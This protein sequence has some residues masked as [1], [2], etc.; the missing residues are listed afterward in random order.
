MK[1]AK[2]ISRVFLAMLLLY[3]GSYLFLSVRGRYEPGGIGLS[4]VRWYDWAPQGFVTGYQRNTAAYMFYWPL[5]TLDMR[6][7]HTPDKAYTNGYPINEIADE[8]VWKLYQAWGLTEPT[9][10]EAPTEATGSEP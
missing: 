4:F 1:I 8:D 2:K 9:T 7:W 10:S 6:F 3:V 5:W